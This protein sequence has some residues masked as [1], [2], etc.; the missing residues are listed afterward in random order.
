MSDL[1]LEKLKFAIYVDDESEPDDYFHEELKR[2]MEALHDIVG[3]TSKKFAKQA[4]HSYHSDTY[5]AKVEGRDGGS[6]TW[7]KDSEKLIWK[8]CPER[9]RLRKSQS[10]KAKRM[11]FDWRGVVTPA[12]Y[13]DD[14]KLGGNRTEDWLKNS[15]EP[16]W[17]GPVQE[18][19]E[20]RTFWLDE[21]EGI[22]AGVE[23]LFNPAGVVRA[24]DN[25]DYQALWTARR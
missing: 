9:E 22:S 11:V 6:T 12:K 15:I 1:C 17:E 24:F 10:F 2:F 20:V 5:W 3:R 13:M 14:W 21:G 4:R 18:P 23:W 25:D 7:Q 16:T 19:Y 8:D